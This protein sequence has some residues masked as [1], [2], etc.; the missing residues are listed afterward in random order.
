MMTRTT[1]EATGSVRPEKSRTAGAGRSVAQ[2]EPH[3]T[4]RGTKMRM[5]TAERR[6]FRV[7]D[8]KATWGRLA[9]AFCAVALWSGLA[10]AAATGSYDGTLVM[11]GTGDAGTATAGLIDTGGAVSGTLAIAT[12][13]GAISGIFWVTGKAPG[14]GKQVKVSGQNES[15]TLLKYKG[16]ATADGYTGKAKFTTSAGKLKGTLVLVRRGGDDLPEVCASPFF[17]GQVMGR[18][19]T[20]IC[21]NCHVQ[22]GIAQQTSFK[23]VAADPLTTQ[24]AVALNID[25]TTPAASR[26]LQK[27]LAAVPH[28]GGAQLQASSEEYQILEQWVNQVAA[29]THCGGGGDVPMAPLEPAELLVRASMDLR[30]MRPSLAE[31][32]AVEAN[33]SQYGLFVDQYLHSPQFLERVKDVFDD[34]LLVRREDFSDESRTETDAIYGEALELIAYIAGNDRPFTEIGTADYT[35]ANDLFQRDVERMPYPMDAV[36]GASWQPAHYTDGRPHAGLLSTSAFYEVWDTNNT[37]LNRRRANRWSIVFHCYNFLD[38]P[39]DVTRDVDN[40]DDDAVLNAVTTRTDCKACHDRLDPM[41]SFLFP[42]DRAFGLEDGES[43]SFFSGDPD[44]WRYANR[45]PPAVYGTP[46]LDLRDMG[47]LLT[48]HPKFAECQTKRAFQMLF[49]RLPKTN[50]ELATAGDIAQRWT[51][52]DGHVFRT[53]VKRWMLSE[54]YTK[55]P[56]DHRA[57]WVRR[58]SPERLET[59]IADLTGF[60]WTREPDDDQDDADPASD[61][62]LLDPVPLLTTEEDGFRIILGSINGTSVTGR[63][64]SLNAS[65]VTVHR[66][67]AALAAGA[68]VASDFALPDAERRLLAGITGDEDPDADEAALRGHVV[69][70]ARRLYG[71]RYGA[72]SPE[73]DNWVQLYRNLHGDRTQGGVEEGNVP[74]TAG[75]RAWRGLLVAMLRSPRML[76]Y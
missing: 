61:P 64:H 30:G 15:G 66:K 60:T 6:T 69:R 23:V 39:V 14:K 43:D 24:Q 2:R 76:I 68:V 46:G 74:G 63:S 19:L 26:I 32:D 36:A 29:G 34:A 28:G 47:R 21:A 49:Q 31:L 67:V 38:T 55:R 70:L 18:V 12:E 51:T 22:G 72:S 1:D 50:L 53:L 56:Q 7:I 5:E 71:V 33:P 9:S 35:V 59:L 62:P 41:A 73:V 40:N 75:E 8:R 20:P 11:L 58:A 52:E 10:H 25:T 54:A 13:D 17:D 57:E 37:N 48:D 44:R 3:G 16:K 65:V 45:R 42:T 27:P 4:L